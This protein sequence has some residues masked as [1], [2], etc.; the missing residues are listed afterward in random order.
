[1]R[2]FGITFADNRDAGKIKTWAEMLGK[3]LGSG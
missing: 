1:V 2:F 3:K